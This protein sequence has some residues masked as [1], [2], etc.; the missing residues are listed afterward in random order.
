MR[1]QQK[2]RLYLVLF[3]IAGVSI[4]I[5]LMLFALGKN[6]NMFYTP[7]QIVAKEAPTQTTIRVGGLVVSGSVKRQSDSLAVEFVLTDQTEQIA[8]HYEGIL[9]DLFR[10]GQ[11]IIA[12]GQLQPNGIVKA[13]QVLAKHDETYMPPEVAESL[14]AVHQ[15]DSP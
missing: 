7:S 3:I 6:V 15:K 11:G 9:P 13:S 4:A 2:Q 8:V 12:L 10:E 1:T 14:K 5:G